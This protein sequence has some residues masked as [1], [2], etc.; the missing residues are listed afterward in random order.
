MKG[1][2]IK[3]AY[4]EL[5]FTENLP[6]KYF[7]NITSGTETIHK[8]KKM[9]L[10]P[11]LLCVL[12][13]GTTIYGAEKLDLLGRNYGEKAKII[14]D[15]ADETIYASQ[16]DYL[17]LSVED[18]VFSGEYGVVFLHIQALGEAGREFM[19]RNGESLSMELF[20]EEDG[21]QN[22]GSSTWCRRICEDISDEDNWYYMVQTA[23]HR[24]G[25]AGEYDTAKVSLS[26]SDSAEN[27]NMAD[28]VLPPEVE[29]PVS[30]TI[31]GIHYTECGEFEEVSVSPFAITVSW[32][33]TGA[34][35]EYLRRVE[36][37][38]VVKK[39]GSTLKL[40]HTFG[41]GYH[42]TSKWES[43]FTTFDDNEGRK[44]LSA[45]PKE[46]LD[47]EEIESVTLNGVLC[48]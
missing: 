40:T 25:G 17:K 14:R 48:R 39:D 8:R 37:L 7:R 41:M 34:G 30:R 29:F 36:N 19:S 5:K 15:S 11:V 2:E 31:R 42:V 38:E 26:V 32:N 35:E 20:M 28:D 33:T 1:N 45:I 47:P 43:V 18:A 4:D 13:A 21:A 6:D 10:A 3:K 27:G 22:T 46:I 12:L 44:V 23:N 24:S 9:R 16:N